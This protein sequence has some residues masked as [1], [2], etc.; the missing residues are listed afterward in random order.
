M[1]AAVRCKA[2]LNVEQ[3]QQQQL[4]M[5]TDKFM[6]CAMWCYAKVVVCDFA[7]SRIYGHAL[8]QAGLGT[9]GW[10]APE[11]FL[12]RAFGWDLPHI[13][14]QSTGAEK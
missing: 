5:F 11:A 12:V 10:M 14:W 6:H 7:M 3:T 4:P 13:R 8:T 2:L 1:C 9:P